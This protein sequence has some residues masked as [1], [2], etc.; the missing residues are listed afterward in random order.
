[1]G[2]ASDFVLVSDWRIPAAIE[3]VWDVLNDPTGWPRWWPYVASVEKLAAGDA[4]GIGA[5]YR[6]HW[7]SR[8]PYHIDIETHVVEIDRLK[9]IRAEASGELKGEGIWRLQPIA[10]GTAVEYT[11]RVSV[12]K[13]WMR[14]LAPVLR[15]AFAWNHNGVMAAGEAGLK[16][17][18]GGA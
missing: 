2:S 16:K 13:A 5:R 8:L 1:M 10:D 9:R 14:A 6:F 3:R 17:Y 12:D 18:L 15:P 7:T 4:A 11:W